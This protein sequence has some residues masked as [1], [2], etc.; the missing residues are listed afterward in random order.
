MR[1][2]RA[3]RRRTPGVT[4][5][6]AVL[7]VICAVPARAQDSLFDRS[8]EELGQLR[9]TSVSRRSEPLLRAASA[10][11]VITAEDI[12]RSGLKTI[13]ELLRLAPGVEVAR[14]GAHSW[15]I[16]IRGFSSDLSNKLLVLM[17]GRSVYSPLFAGVFWDAQDTLIEDIDRIEVISGPGGTLWGANAVNGVINIITRSAT[18]TG[19]TL[20]DVGA[21]NEE[22][23]G[24]ALRHGF[25]LAPD[26]AARAYIKYTDRDPSRFP[27]GEDGVDDVSMAQ[28]GFRVDWE[29]DARSLV[30]VQGDVYGAELGSMLRGDFTLGTLPG[31]DTPGNVDIAGHNLLARWSRD[32]EDGSELRLQAYYDHTS[33]DIP[34][35]FNEERD[36]IDL[37]FQHNLRLA[38]RHNLVW[39]AG[40][41]WT[42]D[43]IDN[44]LFAT[45]VPDSR[46]D[47]TLSLFAQDE[48]ALWGD[49][50]SLII[51][52]KLEDNDYTGF[53]FQPN[54]RASVRLTERQVLW[55]AV[56]RA[57]R[58]P[59][60]LNTDLRLT[61]PVDIPALG[62]PLYVMVDGTPDYESEELVSTG[63][64]YR[65]SVGEDLS[66]NLALFYN[67]YDRLQTQE[68]GAFTPVGDPVEY[69]TLDATLRNGMQGDTYGGTLV[70][71]WQPVAWWQ[72][73][74]QYAYLEMDLELK[75]GFLDENSLSV[76]GNSPN[77]QAAVYSW[78]A[79]P[80]DLELY[81]GVR[82][83]DEL[84]SLDVPDY[85]SV[86]LSLGWQAT[87][88]VRASLTGTNLNN[89]THLEFGGGNLIERSVTLSATFTF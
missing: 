45:F 67:Q 63:L 1:E 6:L 9:V 78:M 71:N 3:A 52:A 19:G 21:G 81:V 17:D 82:Y 23:L 60:R 85:T 2:P 12:R 41:R 86:N 31:P 22:R 70:V 8:I 39:G 29:R 65:A 11:Y 57:V 84:P 68:P 18:E 10:V 64:G 83:V 40:F 43:E 89:N 79:L 46:S 32:L 13:P 61:A 53:E 33:R 56:S 7:F 62:A 88:R 30:T 75:E 49:R 69:F 25:E 4:G 38:D 73:Q 37:D 14:D 66:I 54:I 58:I 27:T 59:A 24:V 44:T 26:A 50:T 74:F 28:A 35:S 34:G 20:V 76:A 48:I 36:T 80:M 5:A 77:Q 87:E 15:T 16:S 47:R 51:G 42:S 72:L 55:G